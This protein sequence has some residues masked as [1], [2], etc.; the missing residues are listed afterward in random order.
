[1]PIHYLKRLSDGSKKP[2]ER[3]ISTLRKTYT[4]LYNECCVRVSDKTKLS[5]TTSVANSSKL[6]L[7]SEPIP[8]NFASSLYNFCARI[9]TY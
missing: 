1:M 6:L 2:N 5:H 3:T 4:P 8:R 7:L 9:F